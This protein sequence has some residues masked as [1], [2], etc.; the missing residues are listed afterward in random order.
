MTF[1]SGIC[2]CSTS[3][4]FIAVALALSKRLDLQ[5]SLRLEV[6]AQ[7][8]PPRAHGGQACRLEA[9]GGQRRG[10]R[11]GGTPL[12]PVRGDRLHL[13]FHPG[14]I[15]DAPGKLEPRALTCACQVEQAGYVPFHELS[16][17]A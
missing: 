13:H 2:S 8:L 9:G 5:Y 7:G 17:L 6:S 3:S 12:G 10:R 1:I 15:E 4:I 16:G 11:A 14:E